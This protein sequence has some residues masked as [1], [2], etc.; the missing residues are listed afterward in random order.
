MSK[1][2]NFRT[3]RPGD[4]WLVE[5]DEQGQIA[6]FRYQTS[7]E[8]I[9]ETSKQGEDYVAEK[10]KVPLE[11]RIEVTSGRCGTRSLARG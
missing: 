6:R 11:H 9:W 3:S 2:F 1:V 7:L 5:V 4:Q 8:D 10:I